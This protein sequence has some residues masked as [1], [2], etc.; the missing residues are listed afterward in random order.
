MLHFWENLHFGTVDYLALPA[1]VLLLAALALAFDFSNGIH[2]AAN[3]IATVVSTRVLSP[4]T[5]VVWAAFFTFVAFAVFH[6]KVAGTMG[7]GLI[8]PGIVDNSLIAATLFSA[9][10]WNLFTWYLGLPTSSSHALTFSLIGAGVAKAGWGVLQWDGIGKT[11]IFIFL[12]PMIGAFIG[13][14]FAVG[15]MWVFRRALPLKVDRFFRR[16]QL[17]SA[18]LYSLGHG[19]NDAQKTM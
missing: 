15:V 17:L 7:K 9:I 12:S 16:G 1:T 13:A 3:S 11:V 19:G 10:G 18:S 2:D 6:L 4:S 5:A 14:V 8:E